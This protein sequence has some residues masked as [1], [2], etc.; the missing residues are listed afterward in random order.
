MTARDPGNLL[1]TGGCGFLGSALVRHVLTAGRAPGKVVNLDRLTYAGRID[2]LGDFQSDP[3]HL[4]VQG[5]VADTALVA[6]LLD[7]H[8]IHTVVH[9]A[10]ETHVDRSIKDPIPFV[11]TNLVGTAGLLEA[12]RTRPS[13][14]LHQVSTDEVFGSSCHQQGDDESRPY[15]PS[16]PYAATKAGADHLVSAYARTYGLSHCISYGTNSYGPCQVPEKLIP[17]AILRWLGEGEV[18]LY[19]DGNHRRNWLYVE[20]HADALWRLVLGGTSGC[21]Y[22]VP[23]MAERTNRELL[24]ELARAIATVTGQEMG[25]LLRRIVCGSDRPG[26]DRGYAVDGSG[27]RDELGWSPRWDLPEGLLA[28]VRWYRDHPV[29][30]RDARL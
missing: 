17:L 19:G 30:V 2:N 13:V 26:H 22:G 21:R 20:D 8:E 11:T 12:L 7:R 9:L 14:H 10:A 27:L 24:E 4:F 18:P 29:W 23:G 16:S 3:R 5:D 6:H 1:I 28:T 25:Q 15:R